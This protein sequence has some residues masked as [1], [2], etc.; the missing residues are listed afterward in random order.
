LVSRR[1]TNSATAEAGQPADGHQVEHSLRSARGAHH[2]D[3]DDAYPGHRGERADGDRDGHH[4]AD[5]AAR[6]PLSSRMPI[7][8]D[9][10]RDD[11]DALEIKSQVRPRDAG[12]QGE[13]PAG[14]RSHAASGSYR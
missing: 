6:E 8:A 12:R 11:R 5:R 9:T 7:E 4:E 1:P 10:R 3:G 13:G 2:P 14:Q